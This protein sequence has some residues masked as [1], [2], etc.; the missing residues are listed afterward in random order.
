LSATFC[1]WGG[2]GGKHAP[3]A[4]L[5]WFLGRTA[6]LTSCPSRSL[7]SPSQSLQSFFMLSGAKAAEMLAEWPPAKR[8]ELLCSCQ[9]C[10][11][12]ECC[13]VEVRRGPLIDTPASRCCF[14]QH[15]LPG[16]SRHKQLMLMHL[17]KAP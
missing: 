16:C 8:R 10:A 11:P 6:C 9:L 3:A 7:P 5:S 4:L 17:Q 12:T 14:K 1:R 15:T 2:G 13:V